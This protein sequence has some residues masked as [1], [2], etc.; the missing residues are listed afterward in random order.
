MEGIVEIYKN[1]GTPEQELLS[2][3][4]NLVVDGAGELFCDLLTTPSGSISGVDNLLDTSNF[5]IRAFSLGKSSDSYR[6]HAHYYPFDA[7]TYAETFTPYY[8]YVDLVTNDHTIRAVST[9]GEN[10]DNT[11]SSFDP[12]NDVGSTPNPNDKI[13]EH[14]TRTAIDL[15]VNQIHYM[16]KNYM[17]GRAPAMGHNLNRLISGSNPNLLSYTDNPHNGVWVS[18]TV[19]SSDGASLDK[20]GLSGV[21]ISGTNTGPFYGTSAFLVEGSGATVTLRQDV[22]ANRGWGERRYYHDNLD[23]TFSVFVRL[24][25]DL[26]LAPSTVAISMKGDNLTAVLS[27]TGKASFNLS[28]GNYGTPAYLTYTGGLTASGGVETLGIGA[29]S[30]HVGWQRLHVRSKGAMG[31]TNGDKIRPMVQFTPSAV[32]SAGLYGETHLYQYGWQFEESYGPTP[33]QAVSGV[34]PSFSEGGLAGDIFLGCWPDTTGTKFAI[35]SSI[36]GLDSTKP[37]QSTFMASGIYPMSPATDAFFN[38]SSIRCMDQN[39]FVEVQG[40]LAANI[41]DSTKGL[42]VS[43]APNFS[44]V[45]EVAYKVTISSGDL[46]LANLYGGIFK[47]G[48][49]SLDLKNTM[50]G[51]IGHYSDGKYGIIRK[52][53]YPAQPPFIYKAGNSNLVYKLFSEKSFTLNLCRIQDNGTDAGAFNYDPITLIWRLKFI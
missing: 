47:C 36:K 43:A 52:T 25:D 37:Y 21:T 26:S 49:W 19:R 35:T 4:S 48:L 9:S 1:F 28:G 15:T 16:N 45:G 42:I 10:I 22:S 11:V 38:A 6:K 32:D 8:G 39:G 7:S 27:K 30:S 18:S 14:D 24:P 34:K 53:D 3:E 44:A 2:R 40:N 23:V 17:Q 31:A 20:L 29:T 46:G 33:F 51:N 5:T 13:L 50:Q 12:V 41:N